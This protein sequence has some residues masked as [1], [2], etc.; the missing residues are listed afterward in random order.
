MQLISRNKMIRD[1]KLSQLFWSL[2]SSLWISFTLPVLFTFFLQLGFLHFSRPHY[3]K[4]CL[5]IASDF[6]YY[7]ILCF[8][9][10]YLDLE[11]V[12]SLS[13][14]SKFLGERRDWV[15]SGTAVG[16]IDCGQVAWFVWGS[17]LVSRKRYLA[18]LLILFLYFNFLDFFWCGPFLKSLLTL[19]Q[20]CFCFMFWVFLAARHV[21]S[22]L[23]DQGANPHPLHWKVR[24]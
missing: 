5:W 9:V 16:A 4:A 12:K 7:S 14:N 13:P 6:Q 22:Y 23:P 21:G 1:G 17:G 3:G 19:L 18:I 24:S 2:L 11:K 15:G 8:Y 20:Y 10:S